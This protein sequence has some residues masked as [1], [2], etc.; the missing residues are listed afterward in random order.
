MTDTISRIPD[1]YDMDDALFENTEGADV[2]K[3]AA[4]ALGGNIALLAPALQT[5]PL[6]DDNEDDDI[7]A[8]RDSLQQL[9]QSYNDR[10]ENE[11]WED[12]GR[13]YIFGQIDTGTLIAAARQEMLEWDLILNAKALMGTDADVDA[14]AGAASEAEQH[15]DFSNALRWAAEPC[16]LT[17]GLCHQGNA[18]A[19]EALLTHGARPSIDDGR[20]FFSILR[21]GREDIARIFARAGMDDDRFY[22]HHWHENARN[23]LDEK[24]ARDLLRK[25]YWEYGR[26]EALDAATLIEKKMFGH[27]GQLRVIFD[28]AA[29]R[30]SE[31]TMIDKHAFKTE[32]SFD[33]YG[34]A[35]IDT[36]RAKLVELGGS[37]P[38]DDLPGRPLGKPRL[39]PPAR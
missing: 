30:V 29:R 1:A 31:I 13:Y 2:W 6:Y 24:N 5:L 23:H 8:L 7:T 36:A 11:G 19:S 34:P 26:Y 32:V 18:A 14:I 4:T 20:L 39:A 28:F 9:V 15:L 38:P 22:L 25:I 27:G 12:A 21:A 10:L 16:R 37:P 3:A 17:G 35:A 33:D